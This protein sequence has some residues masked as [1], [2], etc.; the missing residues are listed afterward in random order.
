VALTAF[1]T[2]GCSAS[3]VRRDREHAK[4][5]RELRIESALRSFY[6]ALARA[7]PGSSEVGAVLHAGDLRFVPDAGPLQDDRA[8]LAW[9]GKL[10]SEQ[11]FVHFEISKLHIDSASDA[12][13]RLHFELERRSVDDE[14]LPHVLRSEQSWRI[15]ESADLSMEVL[16]IQE[17]A[18]LAF[19]GTGPQIVCY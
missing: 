18:K 1:G 15:R 11:P 13:Y 8:L 3:D 2:L 4:E 16:G 9:L 7:R 6:T 5:R 19:P 12:S 10:R 14:G 17:Q